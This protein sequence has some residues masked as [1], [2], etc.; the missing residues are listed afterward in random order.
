MR[1]VAAIA[2]A[3]CLTACGQQA[4]TTTEAPPPAAE[5][6]PVDANALT[7]QGWGPL[8]I[9]MTLAEITAALGPDANPNAVGG[10]D[11]QA[12]NQFR[13]ARAPEGML[14]MV[15]QGVLTRISISRTNTLKTDRGFGLGDSA[16]AIKA[17]YGA[18]TVVTPHKYQQAPAEYIAAW[19]NLRPA[20][21]D[22]VSDPNARGIIYEIN[23]EGVVQ[24]IH[25]GGPSIQYVEGCS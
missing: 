14:L 20:A 25:A 13:P 15:E 12:C 18:D 22:Y 23:G 4:A 1:I 8:R 11:E 9:G 24:Q 6:P 2:L 3:A 5:Q 10:A 17:A 19:T 21:N 16:A 7:A